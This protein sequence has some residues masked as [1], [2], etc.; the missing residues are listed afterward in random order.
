M[1]G[2]PLFLRWLP[3]MSRSTCRTSPASPNNSGI[4]RAAEYAVRCAIIHM[5]LEPDASNSSDASK[6]WFKSTMRHHE[7]RLA[8][9]SDQR[10]VIAILLAREYAYVRAMMFKIILIDVNKF[11]AMHRCG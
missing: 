11:A 9:M 1:Q 10:D 6:K 3:N 2:L 7:Q 4:L 8:Y 5:F